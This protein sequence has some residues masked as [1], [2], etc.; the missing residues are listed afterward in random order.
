LLLN[1]ETRREIDSK[2]R[3]LSYGELLERFHC[4][5]DK[6]LEESLPFIEG[7]ELERIELPGFRFHGRPSAPPCSHPSN[8]W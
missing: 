8:N 4:L 1:T 3:S 2:V 6:R 7:L 5:V